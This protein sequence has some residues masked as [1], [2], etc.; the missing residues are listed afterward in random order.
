MSE[1]QHEVMAAAGHLDPRK[2]VVPAEPSDYYR[3]RL[4]VLEYSQQAQGICYRQPTATG[5]S[6]RPG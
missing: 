1:V 4:L 6:R 5:G 2:R 3:Q